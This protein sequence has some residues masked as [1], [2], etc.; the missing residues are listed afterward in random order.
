[1][2]A[3][4]W[5]HAGRTLSGHKTKSSQNFYHRLSWKKQKMR[6]SL[7]PRF[8]MIITNESLEHD[9]DVGRKIFMEYAQEATLGHDLYEVWSMHGV[10]QL[11][12]DLHEV[13]TVCCNTRCN[14]QY[15]WCEVTLVSLLLLPLRLNQVC[16]I[17]NHWTSASYITCMYL[18]V[19]HIKKHILVQRLNVIYSR[20]IL[21]EYRWVPDFLPDS[22]HSLVPELFPASAINSNSYS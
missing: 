18:T 22:L 13:C 10:L 15:E 14:T 16:S 19:G 2:A 12:Q 21:S 7:L 9:A 6:K 3:V 11:S 1:M 8:F 5:W 17:S 20:L 4:R